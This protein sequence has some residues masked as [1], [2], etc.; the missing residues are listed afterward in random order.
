MAI[1][2]LPLGSAMVSTTFAAAV[3]LTPVTI[4]GVVLLGVLVLA[5]DIHLVIRQQSLKRVRQV[6]SSNELKAND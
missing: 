6:A 1:I 3:E 2:W 4:G 5:A